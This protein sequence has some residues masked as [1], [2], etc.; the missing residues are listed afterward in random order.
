M[1]WN[2]VWYC[3]EC[4]SPKQVIVIFLGIFGMKD[5]EQTLHLES[6]YLSLWDI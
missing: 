3:F 2:S 5:M 6:P 1:Q 4:I